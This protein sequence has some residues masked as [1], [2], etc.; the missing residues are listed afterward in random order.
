MRRQTVFSI[1]ISIC[2]SFKNRNFYKKKKSKKN[3]IK[4]EKEKEKK[5]VTR[6]RMH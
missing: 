4:M 5:N 1:N 2:G 3:N 6:S